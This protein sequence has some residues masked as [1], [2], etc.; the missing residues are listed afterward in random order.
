MKI[1]QINAANYLST[2]GIMY[3]ISDFLTENHIEN[4]TF[5]KYT[6]KSLKFSRNNHYF[7]GNR[8][9]N[10]L[11]RY[12]SW[13]TDFQDYGTVFGTIKL[14][15][16]I[17]KINP[18]IVHLHD[19]VGW[20]LNIDILFNYLKKHNKKIIW[21]FHDCWAF[22]GRCIYFDSINCENWKK[23]CDKC[24][25]KKYY[26][27]TYFFDNSKW[28]FI[29][30]KKN[31][32]SISN[33]N[34][35]I[36]TPS[37]WLENLV[38]QSFLKDY[39]CV[40]INNGIDVSVFKEKDQD[41]IRNIKNKYLIP[42]NKKILLGVASVWSKRKGL[43]DFKK[44]SKILDDD[45][46]IILVGVNEEEIKNNTLSNCKMILRTDNKDELAALY[47]MSSIYLNLTYEDNYPTT[48]LEAIACNTPVITYNTGGSPESL[49]NNCGI[50]VQQ[51]NI[52][53]VKNA[54]NMIVSNEE[55]YKCNCNKKSDIFYY[56]NSY[57]KYLELYKKMLEE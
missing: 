11:H 3:G 44:L 26:P 24:P 14:I 1:I 31:F 49:E 56:K 34:L 48:N 40:V 18:D 46:Y 15:K 23:V 35:I 42:E 5:S 33:S 17:E 45:Y 50:V 32:T 41:Y 6:K 55:F 21:T 53:E 52:E 47:S 12:F 9:E 19:I 10:T 43:N 7:I 20:Y 22:T 28:N 2:G 30:K 57:K 51:G 27:G 39:E 38:S 13:I 25:Q 36:V 16:K 4:Y 8:F 54:I 37:Y 29:R